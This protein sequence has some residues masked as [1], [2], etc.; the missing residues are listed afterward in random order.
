MKKIPEE[1]SGG[2]YA[3]IALKSGASAIPIVGG[4]AAELIGLINTPLEKRKVEW[5]NSL[6][7][8]VEELEKKGVFSATELQENQEFITAV[9]HAT[10]IA[11]RSHE[12]EKL[13]ALRNA[14]IN[15]AK[16]L[17][18]GRNMRMIFLSYIDLLSPWHLILLD[19]FRNPKNACSA[20][21]IDVRKYY[22]GEVSQVLEDCFQELRGRRSFYDLIS[23]DLLSKGLISSDGLHTTMSAGGMVEKRTTDIGDNFLHFISK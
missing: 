2:D 19:F 22:M 9:T 3:I 16:K 5:L 1:K 14:V 10:Q 7:K 12:E 18:V 23:A 8:K 20:K 6:A 13:N 21:G 11:I 17:D 4:P 15:T